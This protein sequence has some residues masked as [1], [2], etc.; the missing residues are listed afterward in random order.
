[1]MKL[2]GLHFLMAVG[3]YFFQNENNMK[4]KVFLSIA[5]AFSNIMVI[6]ETYLIFHLQQVV[7]MD[8]TSLDGSRTL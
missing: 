1:M 3:V 7:A 5:V 2:N 4:T 6:H 8:T